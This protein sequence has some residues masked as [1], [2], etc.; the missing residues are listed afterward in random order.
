[1]RKVNVSKSNGHA[2]PAIL[3]PAQKAVATKKRQAAELLAQEQAKAAAYAAMTPGQ[4]SAVT[5]GLKLKADTA[6]IPT[7]VSVTIPTPVSNASAP[8][9]VG[10]TPER[11]AA[12]LAAGA[13]AAAT[14]RNMVQNMPNTVIETGVTREPAMSKETLDRLLALAPSLKKAG[15]I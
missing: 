6:I 7:P 2:I 8:C 1:M 13:K 15:L 3:S 5:K 14:K 4:K 10:R 12:L 11:H 9:P